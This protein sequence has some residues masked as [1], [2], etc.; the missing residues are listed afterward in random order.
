MTEEVKKSL[1]VVYKT[2]DQMDIY[3]H[4]AK[5][6][7]YDQETI[8]PEKAMEEQGEITAFLE[9][10]AFALTKTK[11]YI[12]A[13]AFLYKNKSMLDEFDQAMITC[14]YEDYLKN[15]NLTS[16]MNHRFSLIYNKA[17]VDWVNAKQ[18]SDFS[19]FEASL[20]KV[21]DTEIRKIGLRERKMKNS[22]DNL[23]DDYEKGMTVKDLDDYFEK[24]KERLIPLLQKIVCSKKKIRTDFLSR[25]VTKAQQEEMAAY[26]LKIMGF[27]FTRGAFTTSEH[28]FT[29]DLGRNDVRVTTHYY[30]DMFY[31]SMFSIIHEGGHALFEQYQPQENYEHHL[32]NKTMGQHE[33]VSRFYEN[34]IGRSRSFI[35]LIYPKAKE[36]FPQVFADVS[37]QEFYEAMNVVQPS[38]IRTES[39][40]FTYTF[41]I[42]IR[43]ELEKEIIGGNVC[44]ADLPE[45]WN[46]KYE[47]YLGIR[48]QND[49]DGIL[50]DM[51]WTSGFGYF[52]TYALGNMYNAMYYNR[53]AQDLDIEKCI[54]D[55][56]LSRI[57]DWMKKHVWEKADRQAPKKW[58]NEI[59]ERDFTPD[60][61]L[62]YLT[63][64]YTEIYEL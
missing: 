62:D 21:R 6:L 23:L 18:K 48:P 46:R 50:Q 14:E 40:E 22:Y 60:D 15:K 11:K 49:R 56:Q 25:A 61:F 3:R 37:E 4:A 27:D 63:E 47:E 24:C 20:G 29:D 32:Y 38:L 16:A 30:S 19:V 45:M 8:C 59:T 2:M 17:F 28:P 42:I 58:L 10:K 52:P 13:V 7:Q 31:S 12:D 34:R 39:D 43:Y 26:L 64:K 36:I 5:V 9:N 33:S 51:H 35:H 54:A 55:G 44:I 53:M 41:H 1:G 57:N